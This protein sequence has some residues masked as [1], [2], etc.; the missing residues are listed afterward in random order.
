MGDIGMANRTHHYHEGGGGALTHA[1]EEELHN[2]SGKQMYKNSLEAEED[3][4]EAQKGYGEKID[5]LV[6]GEEEDKK[7][8]STKSKKNMWRMWTMLSPE[9]YRL[10]LG[11]AFLTVSSL[12]QIFIPHYRTLILTHTLT[13][14][15]SLS[16]A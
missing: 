6:K 14:S 15:V 10:A 9:R 8:T 16:S 7:K 2:V 12:T 4:V 13:H 11:F 5:L 1:Y 3:D